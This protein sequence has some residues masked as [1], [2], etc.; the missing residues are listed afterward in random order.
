MI[1]HLLDNPAWSALCSVQAGFAVGGDNAKR[2][3]KGMLP[4]AALGPGGRVADLDGL[5]D[6]GESFYLIGELPGLPANWAL[7]LELPCAQLLGP[8]YISD[9]PA[10]TEEIVYL[11]EQDKMEMFGLIDGVQPGYYLPDTRQLGDYFGIRVEGRLVSMAGE[12]MR[13]TG[14]SEISAVC[15]LPEFTGRGFAQQLIAHVCKAEVAAGVQPFLHVSKANARA[16]RLY[17][18]LGFRQRRD[19]SFYRV[20]KISG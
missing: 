12:R 4:F 20:K 6:A 3:R 16:L 11:G 5:I 1:P 10:V 18:H 13:L 7:Q 15:T 14:L 17:E 9:L 2:Y 8:E 19:I